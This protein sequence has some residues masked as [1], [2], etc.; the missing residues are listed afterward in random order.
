MKIKKIVL[1]VLALSFVVS[2]SSCRETTQEKVENATEAVG[3]DIG[4]AV[5]ATGETIEEGVD[6]LNDEIEEERAEDRVEDDQY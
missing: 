3:E 5:E 4:N 6:N 2:I 1:S